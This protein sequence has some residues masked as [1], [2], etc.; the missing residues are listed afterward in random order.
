MPELEHT[1][2][3]LI[4]CAGESR[5]WG[6]GPKALLR[7]GPASAIER[8]LGL[9]RAVGV[10]SIRVVV[11]AHSEQIRGAL[12]IAV[13]SQAEW[14]EHADWA[15]GRTGSVQRGLT[16]LA[17]DSEVLLW[18]VDHPFV[19]P[20][21]VDRLLSV[22]EQDQIA[23]WLIPEH[24]G[25][26]GHPVL[27]KPPAWRAVFSLSPG[28][29]LRK[30]LPYLGPQVLRVPVDDPGV[31]VNLNTPEEYQRA[32]AAGLPREEATWTAR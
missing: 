16:D 20:G 10:T 12:P 15:R 13:R 18:P 23:T 32:L 27:L 25:R 30:I 22:A 19:S 9:L 6:G 8:I 4:L 5:R 1:R 2:V 29:S 3:G 17:P 24:L 11:G 7:V 21:T 14:I 26:G 28:D 31:G